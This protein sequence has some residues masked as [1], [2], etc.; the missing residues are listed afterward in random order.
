MLQVLENTNSCF[1]LWVFISTARLY[2][3][4]DFVLIGGKVVSFLA[5]LEREFIGKS[6]VAIF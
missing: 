3:C 4:L 5:V 2:H 6:S 1:I